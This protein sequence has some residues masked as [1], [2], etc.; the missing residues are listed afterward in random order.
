MPRRALLAAIAALFVATP[1]AVHAESGITVSPDHSVTIV[2]KDINGER[3]AITRNNDDRSVVGN[4]FDPSGGPARFVWCGEEG[5]DGINLSFTC[6]G[7]EA[8]VPGADCADQWSALGTVYLPASFFNAGGGNPTPR[9]TPVPTPRPTSQPT[10]PPPNC[11]TNGPITNLQRDCSAYGYEYRQGN[12]LF[13]L[14]SNG[15][16]VATCFANDPTKIL[17]VGGQVTGATTAQLVGIN[18]NGG[19]LQPLDSIGSLSISGSTLRI[20][21]TY[22]GTRLDASPTWVGTEPVNSVQSE[23]ADQDSPRSA[24]GDAARAFLNAPASAESSSDEAGAALRALN[25][26]VSP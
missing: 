13:A 25:E 5:S 10:P 11:P 18:L 20:G 3:W 24:L 23:L 17:C 22:A 15:D 9:P 12:V 1:T 16:V 19:P 8:C 14:S 6:Y 26:L 7:G 21:I 2:S 4:V